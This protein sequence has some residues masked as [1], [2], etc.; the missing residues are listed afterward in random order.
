VAAAADGG[1]QAGGY[2]GGPYTLHTGGDGRGSGRRDAHW[3]RAVPH[4]TF[5][6]LAWQRRRAAVAGGRRVQRG[7]GDGGGVVAVYIVGGGDWRGGRRFPTGGGG[8][9]KA[10]WPHHEQRGV[11]SGR[12]AAPTRASVAHLD[13]GQANCSSTLLAPATAVAGNNGRTMEPQID[14][15]RAPGG[16]GVGRQG[17]ARRWRW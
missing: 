4:H 16:A 3:W 6:Y 5:P 14:H 2:G 9:W 17:S 13:V 11:V 8:M 10:G 7:G 15:G 12:R 1:R